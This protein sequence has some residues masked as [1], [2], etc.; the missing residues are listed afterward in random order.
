MKKDKKPER[1]VVA[2]R[3]SKDVY[4]LIKMYDL[5]VSEILEASIRRI[6]AREVHRARLVKQKTENP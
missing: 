2:A 4:Y 3:V 1:P 6:A 5:N